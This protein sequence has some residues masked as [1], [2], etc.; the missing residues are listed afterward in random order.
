MLRPPLARWQLQRVLTSN[1]IRGDGSPAA[2]S[3]RLSYRGFS[4]STG[5]GPLARYRD[6][7]ARGAVSEDPLQVRVLEQFD[8]LYGE[9]VRYSPPA[10]AYPK[11]ASSQSV[12]P[13]KK[14]QEPKSLWSSFFS[15]SEDD[16]FSSSSAR[17]SYSST[18]AP[19]V[20][21]APKGIYLWGGVGCGKTFMMDTFYESIPIERKRRIHFDDFMIDI[22][23]RL[24]K[25]KGTGTLSNQ[26]AHSLD[27][28]T[29]DLM[30]SAYLLCFDEFQVSRRM[31]D[32]RSYNFIIIEMYG[33]NA[34]R[35]RI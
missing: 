20:D 9:V 11:T 34:Y 27:I 22:H 30:K 15:S 21:N 2:T 28:I 10:A 14:Q 35:L 8:R 12:K 19:V 7:V 4:Q 13:K 29:T 25:L 17:Q 24:H 5:A 6:A 32:Y 23:K 1:V 18:P 16:D 33:C 26:S 3:A 31:L